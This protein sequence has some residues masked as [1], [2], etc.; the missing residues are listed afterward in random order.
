MG[1][2]PSRKPSK[3]CPMTVA[4]KQVTVFLMAIK[5]EDE[6]LLKSLFPEGQELSGIS[7]IHENLEIQ[8][9]SAN[10]RESGDLNVK[11]RFSD[12]LSG[13]SI[14]GNWLLTESAESATGWKIKRLDQ[15]KFTIQINSEH[16]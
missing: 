8:I 6:Q 16:T 2:F 5:T 14:R 7:E 12:N 10:Y 1:Q 13:N 3:T 4:I 11:M 15:A 9:E